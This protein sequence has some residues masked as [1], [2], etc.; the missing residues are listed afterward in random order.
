[1]NILASGNQIAASRLLVMDKPACH[2]YCLSNAEDR[3]LAEAAAW[4]SQTL[5]LSPSHIQAALTAV[6]YAEVEF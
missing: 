5:P 3:A 1:M 4:A 6:L 2:A